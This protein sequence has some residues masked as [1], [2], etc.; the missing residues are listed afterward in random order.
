MTTVTAVVLSYNRPRLLREALATV[1]RNRPDEVIL[2]DDASDFDA[3]GVAREYVDLAFAVLADRLTVAE[4]L[5]TPRL[6]SLIN[7]AL[8]VAT[9]DAIAYLCDDDLWADGWLDAVRAHYAAHPEA[10]LVRGDW[11][12]FADGEPATTD[13]PPCPLDE[14]RLTTGNFAHPR[15]LPG[16]V[17]PTHTVSSH[18]DEFC[19]NLTRARVDFAAV[20][21][22]G[23]AGW[24]REHRY[25][26]LHFTTQ[27]E[28]TAEAATMLA[29]LLEEAR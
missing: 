14:R 20:P 12:V 28:Y 18:D 11:L 17:W 5:V 29:G 15:G 23:L 25:N 2:V 6:G 13:C 26:A 16:A 1:A 7:E 19:H 10:G 3:P 22:L 27:H 24:R 21:T 4:R 8:S 9:G